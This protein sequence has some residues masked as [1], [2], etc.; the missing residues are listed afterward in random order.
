MMFLWGQASDG[1]VG[2]ADGPQWALGGDTWVVGAEIPDTCVFPEF[3]GLNKDAADPKLTS[4]L[5]IYEKGCGIQ[6]LKMAF[7]HDEYMYMMMKHNEIK[8]R[9]MMNDAGLQTADHDACRPTAERPIAPI[10]MRLSRCR[11]RG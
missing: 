3:N 9:R 11:R 4:K 5:G 10:L 7:G 2:T 1:Q 8:V 6:N